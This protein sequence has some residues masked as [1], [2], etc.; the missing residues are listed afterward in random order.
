[1]GT[2]VSA[3]TRIERLAG[4]EL[5]V[6]SAE[7]DRPQPAVDALA[8]LLSVDELA[9]SRRFRFERDRNRYI[10]GRASLR[11]L[12]GLYV[13]EKP[14]KLRFSYSEYGKPSLSSPSNGVS[15]NLSHSDGL[16][17]FVVCRGAD[18]GIDIEHMN[19]RPVREK[20]AERFFSP[21]EVRVL[22]AL[23]EG[24]QPAAFLRCWT[25]KEAYLKARG[26]GLTLRLD[27][28]DVT[29]TADEEPRLLR[30][31]DG[32][33]E[34]AAWSLYDLSRSFPGYIAAAAVRGVGWSLRVRRPLEA[35]A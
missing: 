29:L 31:E 21:G 28:F 22:R 35:T 8:E 4:E 11:R 34:T 23:P 20:V 19:D 1:M 15:F 30:S 25:R 16:A 26:D 12:L 13:A 2:A 24:A 14:R 3:E 33:A 17:V 18:V 9:R 32:P 5:H 27:S 6:W 7:L 10:V